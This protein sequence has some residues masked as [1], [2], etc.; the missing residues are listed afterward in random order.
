MQNVVTLYRSTLKER[1]GRYNFFSSFNLWGRTCGAWGWRGG[2]HTERTIIEA[3]KEIESYLI[4]MKLENTSKPKG[5]NEAN[6]AAHTEESG[7][8]L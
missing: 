6:S 3:A 5:L 1:G 4:W 8:N 2:L 7:L